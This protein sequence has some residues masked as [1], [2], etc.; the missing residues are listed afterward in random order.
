MFHF[1]EFFDNRVLLEAGRA[2]MSMKPPQSWSREVENGKK[3]I[4]IVFSLDCYLSFFSA[5]V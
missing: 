2:A 1:F 5:S 4:L 3:K